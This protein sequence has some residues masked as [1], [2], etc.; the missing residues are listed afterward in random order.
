MN[1]IELNTPD[2]LE[3]LLL[4][5]RNPDYQGVLIFKHSTRCSLSKM[6]LSR[7]ERNWEL[8]IAKTPTYLLDLLSFPELSRLI[9]EKFEVHHES[10]QVLLIR[11]NKCVYYASH[12]SISAADIEEMVLVNN[13]I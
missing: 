9:S 13:G 3:E 4:L 2:Q 5:S 7:L 10:P 11:D 8:D 12:N 6:A 1:W